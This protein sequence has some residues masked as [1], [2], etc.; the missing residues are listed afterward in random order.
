MARLILLRHGGGRSLDAL[1]EWRRAAGVLM[2]L[3][4]E[5]LPD[6][7]MR[8]GDGAGSADGASRA[9]GAEAG[10]GRPACSHLFSDTCLGT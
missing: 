8:G 5:A 2:R 3:G 10:A 7:D 6:P 1:R 4:R 9:R